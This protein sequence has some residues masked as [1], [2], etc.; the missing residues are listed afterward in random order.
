MSGCGES[1]TPSPLADRGRQTYLAQCT[2]CHNADP[3]QPGSLGPPVQ[4][5]S[6]ELIDAKVVH[7]RSPEGY[8]PKRPTTIMQPM[9]HL[10]PEVPALAEYLK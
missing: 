1:T 4:G 8:T 10:A 7:G 9:P 2:A 3:S 5:S 6:R